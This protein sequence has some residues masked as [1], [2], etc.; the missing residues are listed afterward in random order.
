MKGYHMRNSLLAFGAAVTVSAI[1]AEKKAA[2]SEQQMQTD[3]GNGRT[4]AQAHCTA[5]SRSLVDR[6]SHHFWGK[7]RAKR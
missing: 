2:P 5:P 3:A 1:A 7:D 4:A 6:R